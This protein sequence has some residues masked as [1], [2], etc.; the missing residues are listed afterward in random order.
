MSNK[1]AA[2]RAGLLLSLPVM[3][4]RTGGFGKLRINVEKRH[5][6][7]RD[8]LQLFASP[9]R[10]YD[11]ACCAITALDGTLAIR[12][13]VLPIMAA[14]ASGR[15]LVSNM[16]RMHPPVRLHLR[17]EVHLV[18]RFGFRDQGVHPLVILVFSTQVALYL[19]FRFR[20]S[21]DTS[22]DI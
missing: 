11:M 7:G 14:E 17:E 20:F 19:L 16:V 18:N 3:A 5:P 4:F 9:L 22:L 12:G 1:G 8:L 21:T 15:V 10:N 2:K 13:H 6:G